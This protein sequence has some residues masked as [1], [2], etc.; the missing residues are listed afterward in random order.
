MKNIIA[1]IVLFSLLSTVLNA[2]TKQGVKFYPVEHASFVIQD[3]DIT[4]YVDPVGALEKYSTFKKPDIILLTHE[5]GDHF[6]KDLII[7]LMTEKTEIIGSGSVIE[8]LNI[9]K[10]LKNN[11]SLNILNIKIEA[12]PMYNT[13]PERLKYHKKGNGNG[14]V[15]TLKNQRIYISGDTEDIPEMRALKNIDHAFICMNLPYT[16]TPEQAAS[17]VLEMKPN[18]VYRYHYRTAGIDNAD[19]LNRFKKI[20][21]ENSKIRIHNLDWYNEK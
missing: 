17:A 19:I 1:L 12:I 13:T 2:K 4:I 9:G 14:Y 11:E 3:N 16:M 8:K 20:V 5:H 18:N 7:Q 21:S 10:S 6:N 15:L